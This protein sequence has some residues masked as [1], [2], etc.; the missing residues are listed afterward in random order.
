MKIPQSRQTRVAFRLSHH[1]H[2]RGLG[3]DET[4]VATEQASY[5]V[6]Q[7]EARE[8][9]AIVVELI[10]ARRFAGRTILLVG[11]PGSGKTALALGIAQELGS[12]VP[13]HPMV[14]SEVYSAE[15]KKTEVLM[16]NFRRA[17][18]LLLL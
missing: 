11:P 10:R 12:R 16:E 1:S 8:A 2:I 18:G 6:G 5:V 17:I 9:C 13:F 3:V 15:V 4:G 14:A 7:N